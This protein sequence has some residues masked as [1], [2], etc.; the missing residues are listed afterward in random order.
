[1]GISAGNLAFE[2]AGI[3]AEKPGFKYAFGYQAPYFR[4]TTARISHL[5]APF[6]T[7]VSSKRQPLNQA[8]F[9]RFSSALTA[10]YTVPVQFRDMFRGR[11]ACAL[12]WPRRNP[13]GL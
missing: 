6:C 9:A 10:L 3:F 7:F 5:M 13:P 11:W 8:L 12:A 1:M 4:G 2:K